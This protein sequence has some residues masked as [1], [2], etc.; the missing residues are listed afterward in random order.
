[1]SAT[2]RNFLLLPAL[3][4]LPRATQSGPVLPLPL[5]VTRILFGGDVMLSRY[6]GI[7][8][9]AKGDPGWP[10]HDV[11]V[12]LSSAD[13]AF[14]NLESPFSDRGRVVEK[15]MVFKEP[16]DPKKYPTQIVTKSTGNVMWFVDKAAARLME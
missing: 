6:V 9:R 12:L 2:R 10:L 11:S 15:G 16:Y 1:M 4:L 3:G 5:P 14:A 7:V 13:I 8:A